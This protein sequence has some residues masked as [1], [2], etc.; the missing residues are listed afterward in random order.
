MKN[1]P[2][3][4]SCIKKKKKSPL[5]Y[6]LAEAIRTQILRKCYTYFHALPPMLVSSHSASE[7]GCAASGGKYQPMSA[8]LDFIIDGDNIIIMQYTV[9]GNTWRRRHDEKW[10]WSL[11]Q[12]SLS[13]CNKRVMFS[14]GGGGGWWCVW[15]E[16]G[17]G[18]RL[19]DNLI[20]FIHIHALMRQWNG[21]FSHSSEQKTL[22]NTNVWIARQRLIMP[23]GGIIELRG[24][25]GTRRRATLGRG[26]PW[27][28]RTAM[29]A[30][31]RSWRN[32]SSTCRD[33]AAVLFVFL[34]WP[35][36]YLFP[37]NIYADIQKVFFF[38]F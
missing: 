28:V 16:G 4:S 5:C 15:G 36:R 32:V 37:S 1:T 2:Q 29:N 31:P 18:V 21:P 33:Y 30:L 17:G 24:I 3:N 11:L 6:S 38:S 23:L 27:R 35:F 19:T 12:C 10:A 8:G 20:C 34:Q 13:S 9:D 14:Q 22:I 25:I 26:S 7:V